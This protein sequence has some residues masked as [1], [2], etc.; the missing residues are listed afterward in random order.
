MGP[1]TNANNLNWGREEQAHRLKLHRID[2]EE[3]FLLREAGALVR[4][5]THKIVDAFYLHL[6]E[7]PELNNIMKGAGKTFDDLK[8]TNPAYLDQIWQAKF[9]DDYFE[10]RKTIGRIHAMIGLAPKWFYGAYSSYLQI[11]IP[12]LAS[13]KKFSPSKAARLIL[14]F[15]KTLL[16]DQEL[17]IESY[18][19]YGF[20]AEMTD[21]A[22]ENSTSSKAISS[23][24]HGVKSASRECSTAVNEIAQ[25]SQSIAESSEQLSVTTRSAAT[26]SERLTELSVEM[27]E[28][29]VKSLAAVSQLEQ[30]LSRTNQARSLLN[31]SAQQ[32]REVSHQMAHL[33][34]SAQMAKEAKTQTE[35]AFTA[36]NLITEAL[37]AIDQISAKTNMIALNA[38]IEAARAGDAG[39]GFSVVADEV[40]SLADQTLVAAKTISGLTSELGTALTRS[41][42]VME[43]LSEAAESA[44]KGGEIAAS[45]FTQLA[46][47]SAELDRAGQEG[48]EALQN[49]HSQSHVLS[50]CSEA[51][52]AHAQALKPVILDA[53]ASCMQTTAAC[54][55]MSASIQEVSAIMMVLGEEAGHLDSEIERLALSI[56]RSTE[57]V[58]KAR[59]VSLDKAA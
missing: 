19:H 49:L 59:T 13:K 42:Q 27:T 20:L 21:I 52:L 36:L 38:S 56:D 25:A 5:H 26:A 35:Q 34:A 58:S 45:L 22:A 47:E 28:T 37:R 53:A 55:E 51:A 3:R 57:A 31:V 33:T 40:R 16:L 17:I 23:A 10:S 24:S 12:L 15:Q 29:V 8:K 1:K 43:S 39:R 50:E 18:I 41:G 11:I 6:A 9:D 7:F 4:P 46:E 2:D 54:E 32:G 48:E 14:A 30:A 44:S